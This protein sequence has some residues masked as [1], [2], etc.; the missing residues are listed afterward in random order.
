MDYYLSKYQCRFRKGYSTQYCLLYM[1]DKW[2]RALDNGKVF[3]L[4]LRD[5]SKAFD[6]LSHELLIVKLHAHG[7]RFAALRLMHSYLTNRKQITKIIQAIVSGK[8]YFLR[9]PKDLLYL[10]LYCSIYFFVT[11]CF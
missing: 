6:C 5:L 11:C 1:F 8:K 9:F 3:G 2:K 4:L 7:F 10:A